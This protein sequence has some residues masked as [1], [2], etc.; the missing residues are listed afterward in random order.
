M[1]VGTKR[2]SEGLPRTERPETALAD[3]Y[4]SSV[5]FLRESNQIEGQPEYD[6]GAMVQHGQRPAHQ[7][8]V[9]RRPDRVRRFLPAGCIRSLGSRM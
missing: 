3:L 5:R 7:S 9:P 6:A 4:D 1:E 8:R 2:L